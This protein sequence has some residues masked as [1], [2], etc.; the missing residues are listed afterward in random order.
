MGYNMRYIK[1]QKTYKAS[2]VF[3]TIDHEKRYYAACSYNW[4]QFVAVYNDKVIF[5]NHRYSTSTAAQQNKVRTILEGEGVH[6]DHFVDSRASLTCDWKGCAVSQLI[7]QINMLRDKIKKKGKRKAK[8]VER[9]AMIELYNAKM[10]EI[11][12]I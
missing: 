3:V 6:I 1:T 4:W 8:N 11:A 5:N 2:N 9:E 7:V 12:A 10:L